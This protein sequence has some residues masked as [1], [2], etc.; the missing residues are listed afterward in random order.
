VSEEFFRLSA[1]FETA[2]NEFVKALA[3]AAK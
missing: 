1:E 2:L 3:Q